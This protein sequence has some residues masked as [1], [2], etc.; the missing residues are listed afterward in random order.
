M[1]YIL[2]IIQSIEDWMNTCSIETWVNK[3][4]EFGRKKNIY[5]TN[6][7]SDSQ[8]NENEYK[9]NKSFLQSIKDVIMKKLEK[10][11]KLT[12]LVRKT[13]TCEIRGL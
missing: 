10:E 1:C 8:K 12:E 7:S 13:T 9:T 3:K 5:N 6:I 4:V 11:Q 2:C